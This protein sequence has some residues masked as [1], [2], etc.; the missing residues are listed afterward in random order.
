MKTTK[1]LLW[2]LG[3]MISLGTLFY[4]IYEIIIILY[5]AAKWDLTEYVALMLVAQTLLI[6]V[7]GALNSYQDKIIA[8]R[9]LRV[10]LN[11]G[12]NKSS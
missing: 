3:L 2:F 12:N 8:A 7:Y 9:Q 1:P 11:E 10:Q 5:H 6:V 4:S